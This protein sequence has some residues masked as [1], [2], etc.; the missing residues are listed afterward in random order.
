MI[1][2]IDMDAFFASVEQLDNPDLA[3]KPVIVGGSSNRGVV[4]AASYEAR[5]F[6]VRSAMPM[7]EARRKCPRGV[8]VPPRRRRYQ[9]ISKTIMALLDRFSPLV[10]PVSIDE[11]FVDITGCEKIFG[12]PL[13][14]GR[15]IKAAVRESTGLTCS[16]GIAP[17]KFLAKIASDMNKPDGLT[18][19]SPEAA[20]DVIRGL[21]VRKVPGVG[22]NTEKMLER[23]GIRTLGDVGAYS[24]K[25]LLDRLGKF[26]HRIF[27]LA[28][29][30]DRR[31]VT[32]DRP[33]KSV[34]SEETLETDT[35]D[36]ALLKRRLLSQAEEVGRQL[37]GCGLRA[38]TIVIKI[39]YLDFI[40]KTHQA[41]LPRPTFSS[42]K[43]Y[44]SAVRLLDACNLDRPVRLIGVGASDLSEKE[45]PIQMEL[46]G[47]PDAATDKWEK[48]DAAVD[49]ISAKFGKNAVI[50][51]GL[52]EDSVNKSDDADL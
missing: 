31:P 10:E 16:V 35:L 24:E 11:A 20:P 48:L 1:M 25:Q 26:G 12:G 30:I 6:G 14:I 45:R 51:A 50:K 44:Q 34:S 23:M 4:S 28:N 3:E 41:T 40:Q 9:E 22:E 47:T 32:P 33:V 52:T 39:K 17:L 15:N 5:K 36:K 38:K 13:E 27:E 46:F 29:G 21:P 19:I 8:F 49:A 37:R 43:I 7:Y 2:H 18:M 42:E